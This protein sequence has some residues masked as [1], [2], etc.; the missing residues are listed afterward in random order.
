MRRTQPLIIHTYYNQLCKGRRTI[1]TNDQN[2]NQGQQT[3]GQQ[4]QPKTGQQSGQ[5]Q[6]QQGGQQGGQKGDQQGGQDNEQ[7]DQNNKGG[8]G[9]QK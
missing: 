3:P 1:M 4:D 9:G 7:D 6:K 8:S 5:Q 2:R